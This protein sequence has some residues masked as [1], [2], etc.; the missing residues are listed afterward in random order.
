MNCMSSRWSKLR[1]QYTTPALQVY[2]RGLSPDET[3]WLT[4]AMVESGVSSA[5]HYSSYTDCWVCHQVKLVWP[6]D[7]AGSLVDKHSTGG[8]GD[9]AGTV[10]SAE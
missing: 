6:V 9:K 3:T 10:T 8:V 1:Y 7:W 5:P 2:I 4:R